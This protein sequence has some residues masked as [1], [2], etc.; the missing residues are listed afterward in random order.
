MDYVA[1]IH[2]SGLSIY[3][4]IGVDDETLW[5]PSDELEQLLNQALV[6]KSLDG[7]ALRTRSRVAKELVCTAL[8]Y[9]IPKSFI[10]TNP[11]FPGQ[12]FDTYVQKANN[13]QIWNEEVSPNRR[14][15][16]IR[17]DDGNTIT[18]VK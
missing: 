14:Y 7:L 3:D 8:G 4:A 5:I 6:G 13:L 9:P 2:N 15:V 18:R 11:R 17:L 16:L 12:D 10:K 1:N